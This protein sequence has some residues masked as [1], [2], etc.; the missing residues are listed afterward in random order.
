MRF[1]WRGRLSCAQRHIILI[2]VIC[3]LIRVICVTLDCF[4]ACL[5]A[6]HLDPEV[7]GSVA[8]NVINHH[9]DAGVPHAAAHAC[10]RDGG[11]YSETKP[12]PSRASVCVRHTSGMKSM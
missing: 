12:W 8:V 10:R 5:A 2:C 4:V 1:A 3:A 6:M 7:G 9:G 11:K